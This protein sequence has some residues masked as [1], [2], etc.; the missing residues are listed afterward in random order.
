MRKSGILLLCIA[1]S[2]MF[3]GGCSTS[4]ESIAEKNGWKLGAQTY[5]FNHF[6]LV[7][8]LDKMHYLNL[9]Y[10][11]VYFGQPLGEGFDTSEVMD[12][13]LKAETQ[14][15]ILALAKS[16][17]IT[18]KACG[19]V[20]C[21]NNQE[22]LDLFQFAKT[23]GIETITCEPTLKQLKFVDSLANVYNIDIAIHNHPKPSTYWNPDTLMA[24]IDGLGPHMGGCADVGH[25]ERMGINP[26]EALKKYQGRL[27]SLHFKDIAP[28]SP[29]GEAAG[30]FEG[31]HDVIWGQGVC[32]VDSMLTEL[33]RQKFKGLF[34]IEYEHNWDNSVPDIEVSITYFNQVVDKLFK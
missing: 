4:K 15:K 17:Q 8:T 34:S 13:H 30:E 27:K 24:A 31:Q 25:W 21:E 10:A 20:V 18:I 19:V 9:K 1:L 33:K 3:M 29:L 22:W 7:Q 32:Q 28:K 26:V 6:N 23:M 11:E 2:F 12:Y 5:T 16:K 14:A